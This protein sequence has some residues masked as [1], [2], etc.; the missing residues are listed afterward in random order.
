MRPAEIIRAVRDRLGDSKNERWTNETL[1]LY[2]SMC[3]SDICMNAHLYK[4]ELP[5]RLVD[6]LFI[7]Q[8]PTDFLALNRLEYRDKFFPVETRNNID[9]GDAQ[10]PCALKDN[11]VYNEIEIV[12]GEQYNDLRTALV[13]VYGVTVDSNTDAIDIGCTLEDTF[14]VVTDV[15][16]D[17]SDP[18]PQPLDEIKVYYT[19]VPPMYGIYD[20]ERDLVVPDIWFGAFLHFVCGMALQDDNDANNIQRGELEAS[21]YSR[22]LAHVMKTTSKDFTSS[23]KS[24]M[25][26]KVRRI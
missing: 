14:G 11:L 1:L 2:V 26:T 12:L 25:T 16:A 15:A 8:L 18:E 21:K 19:A 23:I 5:I 3:Q 20:L 13:N 9:S 6:N 4:R 7:Y 22:M 24:K 10:F 17:L